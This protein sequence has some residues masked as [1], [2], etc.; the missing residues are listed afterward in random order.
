MSVKNITVDHD[1]EG[2]R[3]D[4]FLFSNFKNIPKSK[5]YKVIR[6]GE[7]RVNS[8]RVKPDTKLSKNDLIRIPPNLINQEKTLD[9]N[10]S[11]Y[12]FLK[13]RVIYDDEDFLIFNKPSNY[14]VHSGTKNDHGLIDILRAV[15]KDNSLNLC[16]R[17]DKETSGCIVLSKNKLFLKHF[18][19]LLRTKKITKTY[20]AIICGKLK[21]SITVT[22]KL[23]ARRRNNI[24][25]SLVDDSGKEALSIFNPIKI[26]KNYTLVEIEIL[27][28]KLH[29]I[30]AHAESIKHP[31]LGDFKYGN[32]NLFKEFYRLHPTF[33]RLA[34]HSQSIAFLNIDDQ[35]HLFVADLS[36]DF[37]RVT[38]IFS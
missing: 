35:Q 2:R 11:K 36:D 12:A 38:K 28:G 13:D 17:L 1:N 20:L 25:T 32:I 24:K 31:V 22:D 27:T 29:Q 8:K 10:I 23:I 18:N 9:I 21:K 4:N 26:Y 7:V 16:H 19:G 33:K 5:I 14:A 30:R 3:V 37:Q 15:L 6:K 34:L